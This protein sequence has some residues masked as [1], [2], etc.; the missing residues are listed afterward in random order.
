VFLWQRETWGVNLTAQ[1]LNHS[2]CNMVER[3]GGIVGRMRNSTVGKGNAP[4]KKV[5]ERVTLT[6]CCVAKVVS[7]ANSLTN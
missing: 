4:R 5:S 1:A 7:E 3:G 6:Q 2:D